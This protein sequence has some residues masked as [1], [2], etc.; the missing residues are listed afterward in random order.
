M[1]VSCGPTVSM[2]NSVKSRGERV[3]DIMLTNMIGSASGS[4]FEICGGSVSRG[5]LFSTLLTWSRTSFVAWS[6]DRVSTNSMFSQPLPSRAKAVIDL[7]PAIPL[8]VS[9][10]TFTMR[11]STTSAAAPG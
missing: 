6:I 2:P 10:S 8:I 11:V 5:S 1:V 3:A 9:S 4:A 7:I